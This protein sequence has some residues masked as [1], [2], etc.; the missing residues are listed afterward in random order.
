MLH[1]TAAAAAAV[2]W[3]LGSTALAAVMV[4]LC[5]MQPAPVAP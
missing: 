4:L 1:D 5:L 2:M 3:G